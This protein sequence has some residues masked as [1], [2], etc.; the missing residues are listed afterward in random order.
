M[1]ARTLR[2]HWARSRVIL[3]LPPV[4]ST[5][6]LRQEKQKLETVRQ[7]LATALERIDGVLKFRA[8]PRARPRHD[9]QISTDGEL[10]NRAQSMN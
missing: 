1:S 7:E 3:G 2:R 4:S 5:D 8:T 6:P 10:R 9:Q